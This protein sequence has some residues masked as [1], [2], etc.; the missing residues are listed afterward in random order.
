MDEAELIFKRFPEEKQDQIR[1]LVNYATLMGLTGKDLVSIGGKLDRIKS[2]R[3]RASNMEIVKGFTCLPIGIDARR[4]RV[5]SHLDQRFKLKTT[6]GS[7]NF[8]CEYS[9]WRIESLATK[10]VVNH[11]VDAYDYELGQSLSW[12]RRSRYAVLLDI[13]AG[14]LKLNF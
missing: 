11:R 3:E 6:T 9:S 12:D 7:Y 8:K 1:G 5:E 2:A 4:A 10:K 13:S 14:K